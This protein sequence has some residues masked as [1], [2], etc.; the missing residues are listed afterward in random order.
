MKQKE[1]K[2][3]LVWKLV[4]TLFSCSALWA[5][6]TIALAAASAILTSAQVAVFAAF[7]D[8][9]IQAVSDKLTAVIDL[10][11][12]LAG[13]IALLLGVLALEQLLP[14]LGSVVQLHLETAVR[15]K[16]RTAMT[17]KVSRLSYGH[18]EDKEDWDLIW[19]IFHQPQTQPETLIT[20]AYQNFLD[21]FSTVGGM[22]GI[23]L[24]L[25]RQVW[26]AAIVILL[27]F[28]PMFLAARQSGKELYQVQRDLSETTRRM[29]YDSQ[30]LMS[31]ESAKERAVFGFTDAVNQ[32]YAEDHDVVRKVDL[33][34]NK[35]AFLRRSRFSCLFGVIVTLMIGVLLFP[36]KNGE[37][38][39]GTFLALTN[40]LSSM[41]SMVVYALLGQMQQ[42]T[43]DLEYMADV[44]ALEAMDE[45]P[46][47]QDVPAAPPA[48]ETLTIRNLRFRYPGS[49]HFI[50]DGLNMEFQH[51]RHYAIVGINGAGKTTLTKLLL[52][53]YPDYEGE[54]LFDGKELKT[55]SSAEKKSYFSTVY[56]DF[57]RYQLTVRENIGFGD[58]VR[59][60]K[61]EAALHTVGL[62]DEI[63]ALIKG[64]DTPLG[65]LETESADL[66]GG[67]W[68]RVA[69]A[70]SLVNE[71]PIRIMDE[72][73]AA[74]DPVSESDLY[75]EFD[76]ISKG[77][78]TI[79]I[80][81]RL[82]S[83]RTADEI[84]LIGEGRV[85]EHGSHEEL[86]NVNGLYA[87]MYEA[88]RSW[89]V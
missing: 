27:L 52:G 22:A 49:D 24:L 74:L 42:L 77:R 13:P 58:S 18:I 45:T 1:H 56:Q 73:T 71:A 86:M 59:N 26:W 80:S 32:R 15:N 38:T 69:I 19:R 88:Q 54:I 50:L 29:D 57:V 44:K 6:L 28:I 40:A 87:T 37:L 34:K 36:L 3:S 66:S 39:L 7:T 82:G 17:D 84:Y 79:L 43:K 67:Q 61:A 76:Q 47:A 60:Q 81:H 31:R 53:L 8:A 33:Q 9:A 65:R 46:G 30:M 14:R 21:L 72:P 48:F 5:S 25:A 51:G 75:R 89:Y 63:K 83:A 70:R 16:F 20:S 11:Q 78:T 10:L 62:L 35:L 55:L 85:L 64:I 4:H 12:L 41:V 23:L 68:Q 2:G